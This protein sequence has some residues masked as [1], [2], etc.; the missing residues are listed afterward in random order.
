MKMPTLSICSCNL[1]YDMA[2]DSTRYTHVNDY[3]FISKYTRV[4]AS[5]RRTSNWNL[6]ECAL[7]LLK[8]PRAVIV[9]RGAER[10]ITDVR[11]FLVNLLQTRRD[12]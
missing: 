5:K 12:F 1:A 7:K 8:L 6:S 11:R 2:L 9:Q 10:F 4:P 3:I